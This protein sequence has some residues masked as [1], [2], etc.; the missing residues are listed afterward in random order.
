MAAEGPF[1]TDERFH[2][3]PH[4]DDGVSQVAGH[5]LNVDV[6]VGN[7]GPKVVVV[8]SQ[9]ADLLTLRLR[10][11]CEPPCEVMIPQFLSHEGSR[12]RQSIGTVLSEK[13]NQDG[14]GVGLACCP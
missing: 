7:E 5:W 6:S 8:P 9:V 4:S 10:N 12:L 2:L 11:A 1:G 14:Q 3:L 13:V